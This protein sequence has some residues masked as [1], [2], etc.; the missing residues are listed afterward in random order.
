MTAKKMEAIIFEDG[1][2]LVEI[3]GSH[4]QYKHRTKKGK[5]TIPFRTK[6]KDL[7]SKTLQSIFKQAQLDM[8]NYV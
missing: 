6:P 8:R 7:N 2:Y 5:V 3:R 4:H 1:W